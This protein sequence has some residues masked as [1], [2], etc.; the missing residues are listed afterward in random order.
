MK[1]LYI[2]AV[3]AMVASGVGCSEQQLPTIPE[4]TAIERIFFTTASGAY[5][6]VR[7]VKSDGTNARPLLEGQGFLASEPHNY[8]IAAIHPLLYS[9]NSVV[10]SIVRT[11][12]T[13]AKSI[14]EIAI[15]NER[16]I[17]CTISPDGEKIAFTTLE[18]SLYIANLDGSARLQL[19][20]SA[21]AEIPPNFSLDSKRVVF[22]TQQA[23]GNS[24]AVV[25]ID[26]NLYTE[27]ATNADITTFSP[28]S[29]SPSNTVILF[30]GKDN[31]NVL[32]L[33]TVDETGKSVSN[34]TT[35]SNPKSHPVWSPNGYKIAYVQA[36]PPN[37]TGDIFVCNSDGS[38]PVNMSNTANDNEYY[39]HWSP[40]GKRLVCTTNI[41][42]SASLQL[43][44]TASKTIT[45][46]ANNVYGRGFWDYSLK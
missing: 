46:I 13:S 22:I 27:L 24:V 25:N 7:S 28:P 26:G 3:V 12:T 36:M 14:G 16:P 29:W 21:A 9:G 6:T 33:Y 17:T 42:P 44:D 45:T 19:S 41:P 35:G 15:D 38:S 10:K 5:Y 30:V 8:R 32:Q 2:F 1:K 23:A 34:I 20:D 37:N 39:P 11:T 4:N 43:L 40:E 31:N 18:G